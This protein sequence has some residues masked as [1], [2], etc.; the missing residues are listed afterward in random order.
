M[1]DPR[2]H[3]LAFIAQVKSQGQLGGNAA[4]GPKYGGVL[5]LVG[6]QAKHGH[7]LRYPTLSEDAL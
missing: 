1:T 2:S 7:P 5:G 6:N 3:H 4:P